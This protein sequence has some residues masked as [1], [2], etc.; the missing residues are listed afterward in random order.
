M[1]P[2]VPATQKA[3]AGEI[4]WSQEAEVGKSQDRATALQPGQHS[5]TLSQKIK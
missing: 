2:V 4:T 3:E 1:H 5:A